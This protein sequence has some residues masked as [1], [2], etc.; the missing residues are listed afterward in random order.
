MKSW[1]AFELE[2]VGERCDDYGNIWELRE[3]AL[4]WKLIKMPYIKY[5]VGRLK[6]NFQ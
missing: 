3:N 5:K 1:N 4:Q 2:S 6:C